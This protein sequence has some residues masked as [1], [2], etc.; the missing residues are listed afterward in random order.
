MN[1]APQ[2]DIAA[3]LSSSACSVEILVHRVLLSVIFLPFA[4]LLF[5][6]L[7]FDIGVALVTVN[8]SDDWRQW[9]HLSGK[10]EFVFLSD[11]QEIAAA[12]TLML[13][14]VVL[15]FVRYRRSSRQLESE[16]PG[17]RR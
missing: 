15:S 11:G 3:F 4:F 2:R 14:L 6:F 13:L 5:P 17:E 9:K 7:T 10:P 16:V 1:P 12:V 8:L